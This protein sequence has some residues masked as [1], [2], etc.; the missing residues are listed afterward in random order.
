MAN[1]MGEEPATTTRSGC[2]ITPST[3]A[4]EATGSTSTAKAPRKSM[5][6]VELTAVKEAA[7]LID[8]KQSAKDGS[9]DML[10]KICQYMEDTYLEVKTLKEALSKQGKMIKEQS[11]LIQEQS[12]TIKVLQA[13]L[14][15]SQS[16]SA[17]EYKQLREQLD[18]VASNSAKATYAAALGSQPGHQQDAVLGPPVPPTF[19]NTLF[20]TIDIS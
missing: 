14:E 3:R 13:Q 12:S 7:S 11:Q 18:T 10:R 5:T 2:V 1:A 16:Q 19:A 9:R 17:E 4:R 6:E 8:Q 15:T 20:C